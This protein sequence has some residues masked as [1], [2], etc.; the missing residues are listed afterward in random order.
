VQAT[1]FLARATFGF[2][3]TDVNDLAQ[4]IR[5]IGERRALTE[6]IDDQADPGLTPPSLHEPLTLQLMRDDGYVI[7]N[8]YTR[9]SG[10]TSQL[11]YRDYAWWQRALNAPDQ[12]R[13]RIAHA[14]MQIVVINREANIFGSIAEDSSGVGPDN[15]PR[16]TGIVHY[17]DMLLQHAFGNYRDVLG[18]V[19][20][21]PVMGIFLTHKDNVKPSANGQLLPD[22]NFAREILQLFSMGQFRLNPDGTF[23][24]DRAGNLIRTYTND[25]I[26]ALAR[27]FT[28]MQYNAGDGS[29]S[30]NLHD[31]MQIR[32]YNN[33]DFNEKVFPNLRLTLPARTPT[34]Q[35]AG[36]IA[37]NEE[38]NAAIDH[39][40]SHPNVG[41]YIAQILIQ[42]FVKANPS[43]TYIRDVAAVFDD[44]GQGARGNLL[45]VVKAI[46]LHNEALRSQSY[47]R[48]RGSGRSIV[49][50]RVKT[51]GTEHSKLVEPLLRYTQ[52]IKVCN[53][54]AVDSAKG[55]R[56][57][58]DLRDLSELPY[59]APSVFNYYRPDFR[60]PGYQNYTPSRAIP[61][62]ELYSPEAQIFTP[63]FTNRFQSLL[64]RHLHNNVSSYNSL[65][66]STSFTAEEA[67]ATTGMADDDFSALLERLDLLHCHGSLSEQSKTA[68]NTALVTGHLAGNNNAS[69]LARLAIFGVLGA[70]ESAIDE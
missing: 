42:R 36:A 43:T 35:T 48:I 63:V 69:E 8:P 7:K 10:A 55:F 2:T 4:R 49:G 37:A 60:P 18:D 9:P 1:Q 61:N 31:P 26:K 30:V 27:V 19:A 57:L 50:L 5:Q 29:T 46:L 28:A 51:K 20:Y 11:N 34:N 62:G 45:A 52:F 47:S 3:E 17:Y 32:N 38:I 6:W 12:L 58:P 64:Y 44:D 66:F 15:Q 54:T 70:P 56:I 59:R 65:N 68:I 21:H 67:L 39:I 22:E 33:H 53:G 16:F 41:P 24:K 23:A 14:L 25:D 40:F 13:Q